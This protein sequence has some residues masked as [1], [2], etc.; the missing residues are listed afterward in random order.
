[1]VREWV[2][3]VWQ[4]QPVHATPIQAGNHVPRE[5]PLLTYYK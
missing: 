5:D 1:M 2:T 4:E 3:H